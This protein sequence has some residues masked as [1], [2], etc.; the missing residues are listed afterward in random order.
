MSLSWRPAESFSY[1]AFL[2]VIF[3]IS[4]KQA[5]VLSG[6]SQRKN[7]S[8]GWESIG[9]LTFNMVA[10]VNELNAC[11][12]A[13][14]SW[15]FKAFARGWLSFSQKLRG[16][17]EAVSYRGTSFVWKR[18]ALILWVWGQKQTQA[19][20]S[21]SRLMKMG[22]LWDALHSGIWATFVFATRVLP[23]PSYSEGWMSVIQGITIFWVLILLAIHFLNVPDIPGLCFP[24]LHH[25]F[26]LYQS[27]AIHPMLQPLR[28]L[29]RSLNTT[30]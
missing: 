9:S 26:S 11:E 28:L 20:L 21:K 12:T 24:P 22:W 1:W 2:P 25:F 3:I 8:H 6:R 19:R 27:C 29:L 17:H 23:C 16:R 13:V 5:S 18:S 10:K 7:M 14:K 15:R 30:R 4:W